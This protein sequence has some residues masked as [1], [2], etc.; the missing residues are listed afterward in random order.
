MLAH[1][2]PRP[3][4]AHRPAPAPAR[5]RHCSVDP[6]AKKDWYDIKAPSVFNVRNVGKTLVT[7]TQ[8]TK[9]RRGLCRRAGG[10]EGGRA[11]VLEGGREGG[12]DGVSDVQLCSSQSSGGELCGTGLQNRDGMEPSCRGAPP[13]RA[14]PCASPRLATPPPD[15]RSATDRLRWPQG[16]RD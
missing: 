9:V 13:R 2:P 6:F 8:G 1:L 14:R 10:W 7:R 15:P 11:V 12:G 4:A 3:L 16:P 5:A